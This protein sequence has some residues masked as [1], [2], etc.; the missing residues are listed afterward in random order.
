MARLCSKPRQR[1]N[2]NCITKT[3][4]FINFSFLVS[5]FLFFLL[6]R[7]TMAHSPSRCR[8]RW[9]HEVQF[10]FQMEAPQK[11]KVSIAATTTTATTTTAL[12]LTTNNN[13][14]TAFTLYIIYFN[15]V[16]SPLSSGRCQRARGT[17][18]VGK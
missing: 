6:M 12:T 13:A 4:V 7:V 10:E 11:R 3:N 14:V 17:P 16:K 8:C 1:S 15:R 2:Q 5:S 18:S 9:Q